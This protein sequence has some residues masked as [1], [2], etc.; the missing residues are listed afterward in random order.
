LVLYTMESQPEALHQHCLQQFRDVFFG[1]AFWK[2]GV[3]VEPWTTRR[4]Q[5]A[6]TRPTHLIGLELEGCA[7]D[8]RERHDADVYAGGIH[9]HPDPLLPR[10]DFRYIERRRRFDGRD[11]EPSCRLHSLRVRERRHRERERRKKSI[12]V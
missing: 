5:V 7:N 6:P 9:F 1:R 3:N 11:L 12:Q 10:S 4:S 2:S 8:V